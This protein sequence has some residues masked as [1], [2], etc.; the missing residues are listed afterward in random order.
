MVLDEGQYYGV[1]L[2]EDCVSIRLDII[3]EK[4]IGKASCE[5]RKELIDFFKTTLH[6]ICK[7]LIPA[8]HKQ[9]KVCVPCPFCYNPHVKYGGA[10][11]GGVFCGSQRKMVPKDYYQNLLQ[12][13]GII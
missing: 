11:P 5:H 10:Q 12:Y 7:E 13:D 4:S 2:C 3:L 6:Q 1:S 8:S 9:L